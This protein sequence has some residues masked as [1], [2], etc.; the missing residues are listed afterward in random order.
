[1]K[2]ESKLLC[3]SE[4]LVINKLTAKV[5][6]LNEAIVIQQIHYWL[7]I[8]RKVNN[9]FY[10]DRTWTYN[11]Y[12]DWQ[13]ENFD[14]W[15]V[16]TLKRIFKSLFDKKILI[17]GNYN[18][19]KYDRKLWVT[20][21]YDILD[22]LLE[23]YNKKHTKNDEKVEISTKC[24]ND[25]MSDCNIVSKWNYAKCQ[26]DTM[27]SV[28]LTPPIAE[29]TTE[30][31]SET[32]FSTTQSK[33]NV[34]VANTNVELIEKK[35]H[36]KALSDNMKKKASKWNKERLEKAIEL[37]I[38]REGVYFAL[39][40]KIYKDDK[41]YVKENKKPYNQNKSV[42]DIPKV[43]TRFHNIKNRVL[44]YSDQE[45]EETILVSQSLKFGD[46][47]LN[48]LYAKALAG[49]LNALVT[50]AAKEAVVKYAQNRDLEVP[51]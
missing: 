4:P 42:T 34:S 26:I 3:D 20:I 6:G 32:S 27:H 48:L 2:T 35:T 9:N 41:N 50:D 23:E 31:S 33:Q 40:E 18:S 28:K 39:L 10:D 15:S 7:E 45:L 22:F 13:K 36:L 8:N 14:F 16:S 30:I 21:N 24:Q 49:G 37:F 19:K 17:K 29:T 51:K 5:L 43:R 25:T 46:K 11:T 38:E 47:N 44:D 1:M 12:E